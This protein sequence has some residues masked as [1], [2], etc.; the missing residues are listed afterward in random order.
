MIGLYGGSFD[1]P[2]NGH[3]ALARAALEHFSLERLIITPAG[4]PP[5]KDEPVGADAETRLRL[6]EAAFAELP[7]TE[8]SRLDL[9][10]EGPAYSHETARVAAERWGDVVLLVGAD[11]FADFL[12][13]ESPDDVL[14]HARLGVATRPGVSRDDIDN[15]LARVSRPDRVELFEMPPVDVASRDIRRRIARGEPIDDLVPPRVAELI[16]ELGLYRH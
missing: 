4:Q 13:W 1:P 2:H 15:V 5:L 3:V 8:V 12:R 6:V 16:S 10:L 14:Q 7:R 9:D 11:R